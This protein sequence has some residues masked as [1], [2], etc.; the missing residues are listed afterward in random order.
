MPHRRTPFRCSL[1]TRGAD[2]R[3]DHLS[4]P[5]ASRRSRD[6]GRRWVS[7]PGPRRWQK[8][9]A[10]WVL[11]LPRRG[12]GQ[13]LTLAEQEAPP[14]P[15]LLCDADVR[16]Q[17]APLLA[18]GADLTVAAFAERRGGGF[19]IAKR[20]ARTL[21]RARTGF[22]AARAVV[23]SAGA[24]AE[25]PVR[26]AF[27]SPPA[28]AARS[29]MTVDALEE[30]L[31]VHE[32]EL[33]LSH[34]ETEPRPSGVRPPRAPARRRGA[35]PRPAGHEPSRVAATARRLAARPGGRPGRHGDRRSWGPP[36]ISGAGPERGI[37][38]HVRARRTTRALKLVAIPAVGLLA[39][40]KVLGSA[41]G[42]A[43]GEPLEPA[44]H[45]ARPGAEG[46]T[47]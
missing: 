45:E 12:K 33:P 44:R 15:L 25:Q 3:D 42:R 14:G 31:T 5:R 43:G 2:R 27:R 29:A 4:A 41:A 46:G 47:S 38:A 1:A 35:R 7:R 6:R 26:A 10:Y 18:S 32:V 20:T 24:D 9:P 23:R 36:T 8:L 30:G 19:G 28:S 11:R 16:G 13:A 22:R 37:R 21:I 17:L 40:R 34:R 39:T